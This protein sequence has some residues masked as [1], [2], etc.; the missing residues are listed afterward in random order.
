MLNK[1]EEVFKNYDYGFDLNFISAED[2][3]EENGKYYRKV[4]LEDNSKYG[5]PIPATFSVYLDSA[6]NISRVY[7][8]KS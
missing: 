3:Q 8:E 2:W 6:G 5:L 4:F 1:L 7:V